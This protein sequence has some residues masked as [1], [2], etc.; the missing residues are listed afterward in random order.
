M[1]K[2]SKWFYFDVVWGM[3]PRA[4]HVM[5]KHFTPDLYYN[6]FGEKVCKMYFFYFFKI[7][8]VHLCVTLDNP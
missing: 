7:A 5:D 3:D 1:K 8:C 4:S 2:A 6:T